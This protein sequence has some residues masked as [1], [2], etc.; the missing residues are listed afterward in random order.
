VLT[1]E[2]VPELVL[3]QPDEH[4]R[5]L[6]DAADGDV[7]VWAGNDGFEAYGYSAGG[8]FWA[9]FPGTAAFRFLADESSVAAIPDAGVR[10][11]VVADVYY[12]N[13]LPLVLQ[14]RGHEVLHAS[15]VST[16]R[17]LVVLCGVSGT[18]KSTFAYA[19]SMRGYAVWADDA[20]ALEIGDDVVSAFQV[21]FRLDLRK[22]ASTFFAYE[23]GDRVTRDAAAPSRT[24]VLALVILERSDK[25]DAPLAAVARLEP[26]GAFTALLPHAYYFTLSD[27]TRKAQMIDRY[28]RLASSVATFDVSYRTGLDHSSAVLDEIVTRVVPGVR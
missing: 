23:S 21:P 10:P 28:L 20:V 22:D 13:V 7:E 17:G 6:P 4:E 3:A 24:S 15:A 2:L 5:L 12:R 18:G 1:H 26:A 16:R 19:L 9:H 8:H 27:P 14:L 25:P 11:E